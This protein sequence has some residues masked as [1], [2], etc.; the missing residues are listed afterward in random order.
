M[1]ELAEEETIE[2]YYPKC[3]CCHQWNEHEGHMDD[4]YEDK[5]QCTSC[6]QWFYLTA[7]TSTQ[8]TCVP[9][10]GST[11]VAEWEIDDYRDRNLLGMTDQ[12]GDA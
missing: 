5:T 6:G 11:L 4:C 7:Y 12:K 2:T 3:P 1:I 9:V 8:Y 10:K